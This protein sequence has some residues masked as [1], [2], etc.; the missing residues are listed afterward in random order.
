MQKKQSFFVTFTIDTVLNLLILM[1][2]L[3]V[4]Y[5]ITFR[6]PSDQE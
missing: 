2:K 4:W 5:Q 1:T 6:I 3:L